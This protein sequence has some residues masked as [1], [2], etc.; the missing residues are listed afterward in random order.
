MAKGNKSQRRPKKESKKEEEELAL[1][2]IKR[3]AKAGFLAAGL[4]L[5]ANLIYRNITEKEEPKSTIQI[6]Q[7]NLPKEV[8]YNKIT[9]LDDLV[10]NEDLKV[11]DKHGPR[12]IT[13]TAL[14][15][16]FHT[17]FPKIAP[18]A[19]NT[20]ATRERLA[21]TLP[22]NESFKKLA[23]RLNGDLQKYRNYLKSNSS[24]FQDKNFEVILLEND[25]QDFSNKPYEKEGVV[26]MYLGNTLSTREIFEGS[27]HGTRFE[28]KTKKRIVQG[29]ASGRMNFEV[30]DG[31]MV[32]LKY[33]P[34]KIFVSPSIEAPKEFRYNNLLNTVLCE[35][36]HSV[37]SPV[38]EKAFRGIGNLLSQRK[39]L[40]RAPLYGIFDKY[41]KAEEGVVHTAALSYLNKENTL[42]DFIDY[43]IGV[44][45]SPE[46]DLLLPFYNAT[47][48]SNLHKETKSLALLSLFVKDPW[49]ILTAAKS[50]KLEE[51]INKIN[52]VPK[53]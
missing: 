44:Y 9:S 11:F 5:A 22:Q 36:L 34:Q 14:L 51:K 40:E 27:Y 24:G 16:K 4:G 39:R 48:N 45:T 23:E 37:M 42:N 20:L 47:K 18:Y 30:K 10:I 26:Q 52:Y 21:S 28:V 41:M 6:T 32:N 33:I 12:D 29:E 25:R 7:T 3:I 50:E 15:R 8:D 49:E 19:K 53:K 46:Y 13:T 2:K 17:K 38:K 43:R 35:Y 31:K 1:A